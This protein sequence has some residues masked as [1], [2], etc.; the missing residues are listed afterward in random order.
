MKT[1]LSIM[2]RIPPAMAVLIAREGRHPMTLAKVAQRASLSRQRLVWVTSQKDWSEIPA[3]EASSILAA[4]GITP[5]TIGRQIQ[6]IRRM[7]K[8][9]DPLAKR[10]QQ[11]GSLRLLA[12]LAP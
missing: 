2:N 8:A 11:P 3:W 6:Y 7:K 9:K 4:C 10:L 12:A 5:S 1:F